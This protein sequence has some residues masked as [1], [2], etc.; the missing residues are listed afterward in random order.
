MA[1]TTEELQTVRGDDVKVTLFTHAGEASTI[2]LTVVDNDECPVPTA[3]FTLA[4]A[5]RLRDLLRRFCEEGQRSGRPT[6]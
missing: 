2:L 3:E 1:V 4:E 6:R 5:A